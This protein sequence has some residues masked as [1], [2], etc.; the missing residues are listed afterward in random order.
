[1]NFISYNIILFLACISAFLIFFVVPLFLWAYSKLLRI[2]SVSLLLVLAGLCLFYLVGGLS[3]F[4][5][6]MA[7]KYANK[8]EVSWHF[9]YF[10]IGFFWCFF[11]TGFWWKA[12][13]KFSRNNDLLQEFFRRFGSYV[14]VITIPLYIL[15]AVWPSLTGVLYGWVST[16]TAYIER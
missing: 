8:P 16:I 1:M 13:G 4:S 11:T 14:T 3:A 15:F 5:V 12:L 10:I 2:T 7:Y 6:G 9:P